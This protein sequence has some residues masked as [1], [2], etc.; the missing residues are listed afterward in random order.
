MLLAGL[1]LMGLLLTDKVLTDD[2]TGNTIQHEHSHKVAL[3]HAQQPI[4]LAH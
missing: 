3:C 1:G 4:G 2:V